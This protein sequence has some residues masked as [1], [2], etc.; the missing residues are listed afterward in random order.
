MLLVKRFVVG[1]APIARVKY[2][3][4]QMKID[5]QLVYLPPFA[6][7]ITTYLAFAKPKGHGPV[8]KE[9]AQ[10]MGAIKRS[11]QFQVILKKYGV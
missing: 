3:A 8:A 1:M 2:N 6:S 10:T 9:F 5:D 4:T 7:A 11:P